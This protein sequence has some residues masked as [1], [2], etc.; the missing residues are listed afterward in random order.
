MRLSDG[1]LA[2]DAILTHQAGELSR[3]DSVRRAVKLE[4][5]GSIVLDVHTAR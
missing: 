5:E 4:L 2:Q 1:A 3:C